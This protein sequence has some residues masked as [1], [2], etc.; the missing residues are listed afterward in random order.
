M[1]LRSLVDQAVDVNGRIIKFAEGEEIHT[2]NSYKFQ[3]QE[4]SAQLARRDFLPRGTGPINVSGIPYFFCEAC[5]NRPFSSSRGHG[6]D[7]TRSCLLSQMGSPSTKPSPRTDTAKISMHGCGMH[8][9]TEQSR[10]A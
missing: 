2:E 6:R 5:S 9:L 1:Y 8:Y 4:F 3:P 10:S 7:V